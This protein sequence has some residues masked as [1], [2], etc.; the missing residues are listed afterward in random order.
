MSDFDSNPFA[1]PANDN[2]FNV[3]VIFLKWSWCSVQYVEVADEYVRKPVGWWIHPVSRVGRTVW[4]NV[5]WLASHFQPLSELQRVCR[6]GGHLAG[7]HT[8]AHTG[9][10]ALTFA[11]FTHKAKPWRCAF[12]IWKLSENETVS[13]PPICHHICIVYVNVH[14]KPAYTNIL[15]FYCW[16]FL[17][18]QCCVER[19]GTC[20]VT[21]VHCVCPQGGDLA[22]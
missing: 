9:F 20:D 5:A 4:L 3:S 2:P 6:A 15:L 12:I 10:V 14:V 1:D 13:D 8:A 18:L 19:T 22:K 17:F 21:A 7:S 11:S 16:R